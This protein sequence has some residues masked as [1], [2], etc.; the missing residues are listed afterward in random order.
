MQPLT[1]DEQ[2]DLE[3]F[4]ER[5]RA[6]AANT[7]QPELALLARA[8]VANAEAI[9]RLRDLLDGHFPQPVE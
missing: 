4:W 8:A 7:D 9:D 5:V 2:R 1:P 3:Q 6:L